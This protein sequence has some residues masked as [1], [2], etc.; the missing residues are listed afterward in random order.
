MYFLLG[1]SLTLAFLLIANMAAAVLALAIGRIIARPMTHLSV[2]TQARII[3]GLRFGP[4]VAAVIF[5]FAFVVPAFLLHE[6]PPEVSGEVVSGKLALIAIASSIA[7]CVAL[8]R[9]FKTYLVTRRLAASWRKDAVEITIPNA[10]VPIF[11]I[12][13]PFPVMAVV[14]I[15]QPRIFVAEQVL[16]S[17]D[18]D[19]LQAALAHEYGHMRSR[20]NLK[21]TILRVCRDLVVLPIGAGL[22]RTW[23]ENAE[24]AADEYA[25]NSRR[26]AAIN[27]ASA[28]IKLARIT[29]RQTNLAMFY[30]SFLIHGQGD[31]TA[32]VRR[33]LSLSD[34]YGQ[35]KNPAFIPLPSWIWSLALTGL[36]A[37][38]LTDQRL[39]RPTHEAIEHFVWIIR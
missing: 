22:D 23:A 38:H 29:P 20:D 18:D 33:L 14:G 6:P 34:R 31:V 5:V 17:L 35:A 37:A 10:E 39:L 15:L 7:V 9:V 24:Q 3:F 32:R 30:G 16:S 1:S 13:H 27:L 8:Y 25:A 11:R 36:L 28:L 4:V 12:V 21:R 26:A 19:E 2:R